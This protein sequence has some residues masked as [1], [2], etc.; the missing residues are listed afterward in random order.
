MARPRE[1]DIDEILSQVME[2]F[3]KEGYEKT[4]FALIEEQTG[5]KKASLCVAF[6]DKRSLFLKALRHYQEVGRQACRLALNQGRPD[7]VIRQWVSQIAQ[8]TIGENA[9]QGCFHVNTIIELAAHDAEVAT[10]VREH[11]EL[12]SAQVAEVIV[13]GQR[14]GQFR[15]DVKATA[16]ATYLVTSVY[17][18]AVVGKAA[19]VGK[20]VKQIVDVILSGL[21]K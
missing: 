9:G 18:L 2:I 14:G 19:V 7:E 12:I 21:E 1:F 10:M 15:T 8:N 20:E 6:G 11:T 13:K 4:S 3:W 5:V 16:L 17:G